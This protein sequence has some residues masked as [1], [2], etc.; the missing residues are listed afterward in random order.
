[1]H[2]FQKLYFENQQETS[3]KKHCQNRY[4]KNIK[5][6]KKVIDISEEMVYILLACSCEWEQNKLCKKTIKTFQKR[7]DV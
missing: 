4:K 7:V 5:N 1:M 2:T 6:L 3:K